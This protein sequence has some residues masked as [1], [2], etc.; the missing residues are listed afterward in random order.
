MI[1]TNR[2][3]RGTS[4]GRRY[5]ALERKEKN[6]AA[7]TVRKYVLRE[8]CRNITT[9]RS[10]LIMYRRAKAGKLDYAVDEFLEELGDVAKKKIRERGY[11]KL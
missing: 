1:K 9:E 8:L 3:I 11:W 5:K 10:L 7:N 2:R 4:R 6:T